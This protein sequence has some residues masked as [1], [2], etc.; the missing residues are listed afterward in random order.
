MFE[1][2]EGTATQYPLQIHGIAHGSSFV[3]VGTFGLP[4]MILTQLD[5]RHY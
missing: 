5:S 2:P 1:T 4:Y 3:S